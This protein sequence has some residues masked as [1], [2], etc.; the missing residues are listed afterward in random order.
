MEINEEVE[1]LFVKEIPL[2]FKREIIRNDKVKL[3]E[4]N[5]TGEEQRISENF[6]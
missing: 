5:Q 1:Y 2:K 3:M 4:Q 6:N